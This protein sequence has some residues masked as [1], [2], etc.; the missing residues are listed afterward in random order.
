MYNHLETCLVQQAVQDW[1]QIPN[2]YDCFLV[3]CSESDGMA[4][5]ARVQLLLR[6]SALVWTLSQHTDTTKNTKAGAVSQH[7]DTTKNTKAGAVTTHWHHQ[8]YQGLGCVTT[9][10]HHEEYQGWGCVTTLWHHPEHQSCIKRTPRLRKDAVMPWLGLC[11]QEHQGY[12]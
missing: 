8:E 10:W 6:N 3:G 2:F 7:T 4:G 9:H 1:D 11:Q 5:V 12:F